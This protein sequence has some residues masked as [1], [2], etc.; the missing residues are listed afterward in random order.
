MHRTARHPAF[1]VALL[2]LLLSCGG[3]GG[4]TGPAPVATQLGL[5]TPP[6]ASAQNTLAIPQQPVIQLR[7]AEGDPVAKAGVS[8]T[9]AIASGGGTLGGTA[10][11]LTSSNGLATF[12]GLSITGTVGPRTLQFTST[13]L[14]P[15]TSGSI[16]LTAGP[17]TQLALTT[18]PSAT[19]QNTVSLA[20]QPVIQLRDVS[21]NAV[22][23]GGVNVTAS[24]ASGGGT[25]GGTATV[26]TNGSGQAIFA[27]L[28]LTG[29]AGGRTLQFAA[30]GLASATSGT[31]TLSAGPA[32][33]LALVTQPADTARSGATLA[34]QPVVQLADASGN[35]VTQAGVG[36]TAS[37]LS[38]G[39]TLGGTAAAATTG[40]GQATFT[41]LTLT[42][43]G[44]QTL[45]FAATGAS[46]VSSTP[47]TLPSVLTSGVA[48]PG[49]SGGN[50]ATRWYL[51]EVPGAQDHLTVTTSGGTGN[52]DLFV[53][54]GELPSTAV[55]ACAA[56]SGTNVEACTLNAPAAGTWYI[57]VRGV[58][59]YTGVTLT[60]TYGTGAG[61]TLG[62]PGDADNDRL[63]DCVETG[64]HVFASTVNTGT[65]ANNADTDGD[66]IK[67]GDEV[68]GTTAGL[69]LPALGV[70]AL[71]KDILIE[72]DWFDD[73]LEC[74]AHSHRPTAAGIGKVATAMGTAIVA[75]P[76]GTSG[77]HVISDYGQGG[78]FTGGNL[79]PDA[80]GVLTNGVVDPEF[81]AL[82][83]ANLAAAR[84]G[85]FHYVIL[86]HRYYTSSNS[87]GQAELPGND[88]IV[89]LYCFGSADNVANTIMH[90]LGHNLLLRHGGNVDINYKPNYNS[91]MN[92]LYQFDGVDTD[93]TPPGN[94]V[95]T[96]SYG[97][98]IP[99]DENALIE[100]QGICGDPPGPGWDWDEN[101]TIT[102]LPV[103]KDIN[104]APLAVPGDGI[105]GVLVDYNDWANLYFAG[106]AAGAPGAP[107]LRVPAQVVSCPSIPLSY[108]RRP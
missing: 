76:D 39:A 10:T 87:S 27:D 14:T 88:M 60:A 98:H 73:A 6:S 55:H 2:G 31:I 89:S 56:T 108:Q 49:L 105:L 41:D 34:R 42:G 103:V 62:S 91:V 37:V 101:G 75:N 47:V 28:A 74:G 9:A 84:V 104:K 71:H 107:Q 85:Y 59:A 51:I 20:Q 12:A 50:G 45:Q 82:K 79:I 86:P 40:T 5:S 7:D 48:V 36:I 26:P 80:D 64:T 3:D 92:Y 100:S 19:A 1:P 30:T 4:T 61:C 52:V 65:D 16:T 66:G 32:T 25:L 96:Y 13:G 70:S 99:L 77:I 72:Y 57:L 63:P 29:T 90:E 44:A 69:D 67:D 33:Q 23:T 17:A 54:S 68:L 22:A 53:R 106:V 24:I 11:V 58:S 81:A 43:A 18:T 94:G 46:S 21:G 78:V 8:V 35:L 15:A 97:T 93:C 95:L 83:G 38:G 102:D